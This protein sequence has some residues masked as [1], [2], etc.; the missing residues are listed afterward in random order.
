MKV[1]KFRAVGMRFFNRVNTSPNRCR[2]RRAKG[3]GSLLL[4]K[5]SLTGEQRSSWR[6]RSPQMCCIGLCQARQARVLSPYARAY[7]ISVL[8]ILASKLKSLFIGVPKAPKYSCDSPS[9]KKLETKPSDIFLRPCN[10][11]L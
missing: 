4:L 1:W 6:T 11:L 7:L 5:T 10:S 3:R 8:A 9:L 2:M